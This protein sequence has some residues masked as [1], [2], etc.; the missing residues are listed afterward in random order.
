[1]ILARPSGIRRRFFLAT[2]A[3]AGEAAPAAWLYGPPPS[4]SVARRPCAGARHFDGLGD[5]PAAPV[6]RGSGKTYLLVTQ[7]MPK[8]DYC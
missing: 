2:F 5:K 7:Y 8:G 4:V 6:L 1:M 3:S